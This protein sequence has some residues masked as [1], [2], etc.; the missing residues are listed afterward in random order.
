[1]IK[2]EKESMDNVND[3]ALTKLVEETIE[4]GSSFD[5]SDVSQDDEKKLIKIKL[6]KRL[7]VEWTILEIGGDLVDAQDIY[8]HYGN[9]KFKA[10]VEEEY[11]MRF[12]T[13]RKYIQAYKVLSE[14]KSDNLLYNDD[15]IETLGVHKLSSLYKLGSEQ[16]KDIIT[17]APLHD[18]TVQQ[19]DELTKKVKEAEEYSDELVE[20]IRKKDQ[21]IRENRDSV[22]QKDKE[23]QEL[24]SKIQELE[25]GNVQPVAEVQEKIVEKVVEKEVI[26]KEIQEEL[27]ALKQ[28]VK[29]RKEIPE[30]I[31]N[32]LSS[33][34]TEVA[35]KDELLNEAKS[36]V[37]AIATQTNSKFGV[38]DVDWNSLGN[39]VSHF[40]GGASEFSYM[41]DAYKQESAQ[42]KQYINSQV[43]KIEKWVLQMKDMMNETLTI[44][45]VIY[46]NVDFKIEE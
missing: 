3:M 37:E 28:L 9:G 23:I 8:S 34:R 46:D 18:M 15:N 10:W 43:N 44:G 22:E 27:K 25:S 17:N 16:R 13:A 11:D 5:Y 21:K 14:R 19:V 35:K 41:K 7:I 36:T 4:I 40:L 20:E 1:M 45:N 38:Q 42:K 33:L 26:P 30:H 2:D 32:E 12:S 6:R 31:L 29:E 24:K 39:I